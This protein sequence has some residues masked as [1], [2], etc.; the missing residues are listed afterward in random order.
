[1]QYPLALDYAR[2][3]SEKIKPGALRLEIV[4]SVKRADKPDVHDIEI[5]VIPDPRHPRPEFGQK[6]PPK[7]M[8]EKCLQDLVNDGILCPVLG[9]EKYKKFIIQGVESLNPFY[10]DLFIVRPE[11]WGVQNVIRTGPAEFSHRYVTNKCFGGLLPDD[12]DY[13]RGETRIKKN[14]EYLD[15]PEEV[16]A[17]AI[18]GLGWIEPCNRKRYINFGVPVERY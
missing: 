2:M 16:D 6:N 3:L 13:V 8:L 18:L 15:L 17:L 14:S 11:T 4:G 5:M 7:N 1:M 9:G 10:L 12:Y